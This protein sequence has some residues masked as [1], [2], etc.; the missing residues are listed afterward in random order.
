MIKDKK[1]KE[2]K[3]KPQTGKVKVKSEYQLEKERKTGGD[4]DARLNS[5]TK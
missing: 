3:K 2:T 5:K 4:I 1:S